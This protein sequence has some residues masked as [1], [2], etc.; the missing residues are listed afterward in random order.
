LQNNTTSQHLAQRISPPRFTEIGTVS[1]PA[2]SR[3]VGLNFLALCRNWC[4][5]FHISPLPDCL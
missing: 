3:C 2:T 1:L 5:S 4:Y